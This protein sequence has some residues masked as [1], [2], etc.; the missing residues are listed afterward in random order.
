[1][2]LDMSTPEIVAHLQKEGYRVHFPVI[3]KWYGEMCFVSLE[4]NSYAIVTRK[5]DRTLR[6]EVKQIKGGSAP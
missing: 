6:V 4:G 3:T 1:M 2:R 5:Q